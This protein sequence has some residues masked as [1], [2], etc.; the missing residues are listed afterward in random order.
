MTSVLTTLQKMKSGT[1]T[2]LAKAKI[3]KKQRLLLILGQ[4]TLTARHRPKKSPKWKNKKQKTGT[5]N[6]S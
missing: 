5:K 1:N 4:R 2:N 3:G 6:F